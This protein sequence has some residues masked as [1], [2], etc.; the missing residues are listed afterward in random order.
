MNP[1]FANP[2]E[3]LTF[4]VGITAGEIVDAAEVAL[5]YEDMWR[6]L[7]E[8]PGVTSV[9]GSSILTMGGGVNGEGI[10]VEDISLAP[11]QPPPT[12]QVRWVTGGYF[13]TM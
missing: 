10:L 5:A 3:V 4:R 13:G 8:I 7:E 6:R 2:E 11:D 1:G 9:G 12:A